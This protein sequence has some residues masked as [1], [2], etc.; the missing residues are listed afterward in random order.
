MNLHPQKGREILMSVEKLKPELPLILHHHQWYNGSGYPKIDEH[1]EPTETGRAL[2]GEE[3]PFLARILHVADA[4]EAMTA[5]RPYRTR[6]LTTEQAMAELRKYVGIQ[7]DPRV[8][9]AFART[10][11]AN[12]PRV[13]AP[14]AQ[15]AAIPTLGQVAALRGK[16]TIPAAAETP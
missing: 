11:T 13:H 8:V 1:G 14:E 9:E 2:I 12:R 10:E 7:F 4:F 5:V 6:P 15:G 16:G 3:I